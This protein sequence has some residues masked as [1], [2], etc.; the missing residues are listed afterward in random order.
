MFAGNSFGKFLFGTSFGLFLFCI[1]SSIET[2]FDSQICHQGSTFLVFGV[3]IW[4]TVKGG[5]RSTKEHF[6]QI[7]ERSPDSIIHVTG[8]TFLFRFFMKHMWQKSPSRSKFY[9][10]FT[11]Y[12]LGFFIHV[13][14]WWKINTQKHQVDFHEAIFGFSCQLTCP[15][16][17]LS[18]SPNIQQ[19][20]PSLP[21]PS[22][23]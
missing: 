9:N 1:S 18:R 7:N 19:P 6:F 21:S 22:I 3:F 2:F 20:R 16:I 11:T 23:L 12:F 8:F 5:G 17:I 4:R 15:K 13:A 14:I 10:H